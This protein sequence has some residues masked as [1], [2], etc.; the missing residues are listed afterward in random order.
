MEMLHYMV[1]VL[2]LEPWSTL[3]CSQF[4]GSV[5]LKI[6]WPSQPQEKWRYSSI[7]KTCLSKLCIQE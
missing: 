1:W 2:S 5:Q 7:D 4:N 6:P 3:N